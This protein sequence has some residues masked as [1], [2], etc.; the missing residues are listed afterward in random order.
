MNRFLI[1]LAVFALL[2][3]VLGIGIHR[4]PEKG[5]IRSPLIGRP[6]PAFALASLTEGGRVVRSDD[7]KGHPYVLNV[8]ATWCISCR[9]EHAML[10]EA[11]RARLAPLIGLNWKDDDSAALAWLERLGNPYE[12][13]L[14]DRDGHTAIDWGVYGAPETFLVNASGIVVYKHIGPLTREVWAREFVSRLKPRG[15]AP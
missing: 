12:H 10:L 3:A 4:A 15:L 14:V 5:T 9:E 1:P 11:Q 7:L 6:A 8:W 13:V 2:V